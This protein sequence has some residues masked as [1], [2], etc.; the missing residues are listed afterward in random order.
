MKQ[1]KLFIFSLSIITVHLNAMDEEKQASAPIAIERKTKNPIATHGSQAIDLNSKTLDAAKVTTA[2]A[3]QIQQENIASSYS[4]EGTH[5]NIDNNDSDCLDE[6][7]YR[8]SSYE[9]TASEF[10]KLK[11][12]AAQSYNHKQRKKK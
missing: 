6:H 11:A 5:N 9:G 7:S 1:F 8:A 4:S 3:H 12:R 10:Y 2:L